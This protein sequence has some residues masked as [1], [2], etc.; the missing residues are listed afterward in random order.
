MA[1]MRDLEHFY[2]SFGCYSTTEKWR[3]GSYKYFETS[4]T[5]DIHVLSSVDSTVMAVSI[6]TFL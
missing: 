5:P 4:F 2:L 6:E 1:L 3:N